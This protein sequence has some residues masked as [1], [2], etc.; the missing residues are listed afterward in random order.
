MGKE[1]ILWEMTTLHWEGTKTS[2]KKQR[3]WKLVDPIARNNVV[4][5]MNTFYGEGT[6]FMG[7]E[8]IVLGLNTFY[9]KGKHCIGNE[10][11]PV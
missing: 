10:Q 7:K 11:K 2:I 5:W 9:G 6:H 1:H 4:L 3:V 8:H